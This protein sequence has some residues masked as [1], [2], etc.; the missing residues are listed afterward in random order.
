MADELQR[1]TGVEV[2]LIRGDNGIFNVIIDGS[3]IFSRTETGRFPESGEI[4]DKLR[5]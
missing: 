5:L 2:K 4:I 3:C 1:E